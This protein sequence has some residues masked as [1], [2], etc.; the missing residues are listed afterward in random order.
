M[1]YLAELQYP[2][3]K[4]EIEIEAPKEQAEESFNA[5]IPGELQQ[6]VPETVEYIAPEEDPDTESQRDKNLPAAFATESAENIPA[7]HAYPGPGHDPIERLMP[8]EMR[9]I[10]GKQKL[11][12][13]ARALQ[14][15]S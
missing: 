8:T 7:E 11:T 3:E 6:S 2:L 9:K 5:D 10:G 14:K 12:V 13:N 4:A 15:N 1:G